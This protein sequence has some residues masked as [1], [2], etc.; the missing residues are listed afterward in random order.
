MPISTDC[1][2]AATQYAACVRRLDIMT[3]AI[4]VLVSVMIWLF[5]ANTPIY[6]KLFAAL[7]LTFVMHEYLH[8]ERCSLEHLEYHNEMM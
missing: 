1:W 6:I 7:L 2:E 3:V 4:F 8:Q 5:F